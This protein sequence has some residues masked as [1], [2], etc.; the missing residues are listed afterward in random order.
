MMSRSERD[1][2]AV[3]RVRTD[4]LEISCETGGPPDGC[5]YS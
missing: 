3:E 4:V 5:R 1:G 2:A